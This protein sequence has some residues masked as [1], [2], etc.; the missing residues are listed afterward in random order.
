MWK[1]HDSQASAILFGQAEPKE[2]E[3]CLPAGVLVGVLGLGIW[4]ILKVKRWRE[5]DIA[6]EAGAA[7]QQLEAYQKLVDDGLLD[8]E[9]L[10]RIKT[11]LQS[12]DG[13]PAS[14]PD[15]AGTEPNQPPDNHASA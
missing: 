8:P 9:E 15:Q 4:A 7:E 2:M 1:V 14:I 5:E 6:S 12:H 13:D 3:F 11:Q 10:N